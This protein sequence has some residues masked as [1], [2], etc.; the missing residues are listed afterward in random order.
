MMKR[1]CTALILLGLFA[2]PQILQA[3]DPLEELQQS[4]ASGTPDEQSD[5]VSRVSELGPFAATLTP[6]LIKLLATK[7][8]AL[9]LEVISALGEIG[10]G[11]ADA[12]APLR[13]LTK[14]KSVLVRYGAW[15]AL[16][17]MA[18]A[19]RA[20][21]ADLDR[22]LTDPELIVRIAA[23]ET[24]LRFDPGAAPDRTVKALGVLAEGLKSD[25]SLVCRESARALVAAGPLGVPTLI[26][27]LNAKSPTSL[28]PVLETLSLI[29]PESQPAI[30]AVLALKPG[31]DAV[32]AAAQART[33]AAIAPDAKQ[34]IPVLTAL[35][36]HPAAIARAASVTAMGTYPSAVEM[37]V[38]LLTKALEDKDVSV[39]LAAINAL[40]ALGP[41]AKDAVPALNA[42]FADEQGAVTIRAAE[43]LA[44]IGSA[45]VPLLLKR[46]DDPAYGELALHVLGQMGPEASSA[47]APLAE[48][49]TN[50]G[51]LPVREVCLALAFMKADPKVAGPALQKVALETA[52]PAR[53]AAIFALGNIGDQSALK[54]I[55]NAVEDDD[56][57]VRLGAAW[58]LLQLD[59]K[60]PDYV[61]IAVPRLITGL[62]RP[63]PRVRRMAA[64]TL[65]QLGPA[66]ASAVPELTER[67]G[68]DEDPLVRAS[69]ALA[70]SQMGDASRE[71]VPALVRMLQSEPAGGR[72]AVL[73]ALGSLGPVAVD[74]LPNL[75]KEAL[76]GPLFDRTLAAWAVLKIRANQQEISQMVPVLMTRLTREQPEAAV[77]MLQML[78]ELGRGRPEVVQFLASLRQLP[79]Q[80]LRDAAD[81]AYKKASAR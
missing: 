8:L 64:D 54:L 26:K 30:P 40:A 3:A 47:A 67:I 46:L 68:E 37:T 71:A 29:G 62:R 79:D 9:R 32:V 31:E 16:R 14:D 77:Q 24:A 10:E 11:A 5:A 52:N 73:F 80:R 59:A 63:D 42:A 19:S 69:C 34:V 21:A 36:N 43:A 51:Q 4:L 72:R 55:T 66:A 81:A 20:A 65:G 33:L 12:V 2:V 60:N 22:G 70:L 23:A 48:R 6:D 78:G 44:M 13:A 53:P 27:A 18:P 25:S 75:R 45:S 50:P 15:S 61:K 7:D 38:P 35:A 17:Q 76:E 28:V 74:A 58:A 56:S 39:R 41:A 57:I 49:L 1:F